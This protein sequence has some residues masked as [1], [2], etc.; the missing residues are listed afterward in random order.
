MRPIK[1]PLQ[2]VRGANS[3]GVEPPARESGHS[4]SSGTGV[5]NASL[6][7]GNSLSTPKILLY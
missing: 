3:V 2:L 7:R 1:P 4:L 5:T 6:C